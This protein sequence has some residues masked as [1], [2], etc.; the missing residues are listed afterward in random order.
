M[1]DAEKELQSK[2]K[3]SKLRDIRANCKGMCRKTSLV[4]DDSLSSKLM[5]AHGKKEMFFPH[6]KINILQSD[7]PES[8]ES[9]IPKQINSVVTNNLQYTTNNYNLKLECKEIELLKKKITTII[10]NNCS[11]LFSERMFSEYNQIQKNLSM[12]TTNLFRK[13]PSPNVQGALGTQSGGKH[14]IF[15]V[16]DRSVAKTTNREYVVKNV[17][18]NEQ[19]INNLTENYQK[20]EQKIN[21]FSF[22]SSLSLKSFFDEQNV[23]LVNVILKV[24]GQVGVEEKVIKNLQMVCKENKNSLKKIKK[25]TEQTSNVSEQVNLLIQTNRFGKNSSYIVKSLMTTIL[26]IVKQQVEKLRG[27]VQSEARRRY[28]QIANMQSVNADSSPVQMVKIEQEKFS[29]A[30]SNKLIKKDSKLRKVSRVKTGFLSHVST[31]SNLNVLSEE[32]LNELLENK[33]SQNIKKLNVKTKTSKLSNVSVLSEEHLNELLENKLSQNIK[34][35]N[36][37]TKT[38]KLSSVSVL[39]EEHLN[40]LLTKELGQNIKKR[41]VKTKTSKLS[42][43]SILSEEHL[44]ELL[45]NKLRQNTKKRN[46]K[47]KTSKLS[48]LS[49]LSEEH[50]NELFENKLR[51]NIKKLDVKTK[52]SKLS[53][54]SVRNEEH[55]NELFENKLRQNIKKLNVKTKTSKLSNMSVLSE[56]YLNELLTKELR[57]NIKKLD[58]KTKTSKLSNP[59]VRNEEH[60][61]ELFENKLRQNIKK[62]NVETKTSKLS[63]LSVLSE[64]HLN[65][66]V[67][68]KLRQ[69]MKKLN[70]ETKTS[71]LSNVSVLSEEHMNELLE[72][73][74]KQNMKKL[75]VKTK[76]SKLSNL[77]VL[78]EEHLNEL[79]T[80]ELNQN[81]KKLNVKE[82]L[83]RRVT[84]EVQVVER[85]MLVAAMT[86][87]SAV[88]LKGVKESFSKLLSDAKR[89]KNGERQKRRV[90]RDLAKVLLSYKSEIVLEEIQK[91]IQELSK[92]QIKAGNQ[93]FSAEEKK[94]TPFVKQDVPL[95]PGFAG[96]KATDLMGEDSADRGFSSNVNDHIGDIVDRVYLELEN[97]LKVEQYKMGLF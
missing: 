10:N 73:K 89:Q 65:E 9:I 14:E 25:V 21:Q 46:V 76:T 87:V 33:L 47:T 30:L 49:V 74:L 6:A 17:A 3:L 27:E 84:N 57:Q 63:N 19:L 72:N 7:L 28:E 60:L 86:M 67:E 83:G 39:N 61:N 15:H 2:N 92:K 59:S 93:P 85:E 95:F 37:K 94:D 13:L 31:L 90:E 68:N 43:L 70:V 96:N 20:L 12:L 41:N 75:N 53:N 45:E 78:S 81:I 11:L 42:S 64:E 51:Q 5:E 22:S 69:N 16:R 71:K 52:T 40:K 55:L 24:L 29:L 35:L 18:D 91:E 26:E 54:P 62:L 77:S 88:P 50:M 82:G 4:V 36:V 56:E 97:R 1:I 32:H 58:V 66:L 34:K 23:E 80:R 79:L 44:N 48:S 8:K 38:S